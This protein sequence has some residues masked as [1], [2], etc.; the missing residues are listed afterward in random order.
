VATRTHVVL[1]DD[2]V[3]ELDDLVGPRGRSQYITEAIREK[4]LRE[5]QRRVL[6]EYAGVLADEDIPHWATPELTTEWI[7]EGRRDN[8][9]LPTTSEL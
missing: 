8:R 3:S 2:L 7:N 4:L 6:S 9:E 5:R 1:P